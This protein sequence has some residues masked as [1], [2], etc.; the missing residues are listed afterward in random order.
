MNTSADQRS[1]KGLA[2]LVISAAQLMVI[3]DMT[4]VTVAL[5]SI[6]TGLHFSI[7][8]LVWVTTA[9]SLTFGGLL[10]F[11]GRTGDLFGRRRMFMVGIA[12]FAAASLLGGFAQ[13]PL[14][15][16]MTR[17]TQGVGAAIAS[18]T[19]LS[20]IATNFEE[21]PIRARAMG[22]YAAV[23]GSGAG[24]GLL[25]GGI[26]VNYFSWRWVLF[27]NVP[28]GLL[29]L[30]LAPRVLRE[31]SGARH[32]RLDWLG[33]ILA[34]GGVASLVYGLTNASTHSWTSTSTL[35]FLAIAVVSLAAFVIA[36]TKVSNPL[37][38]L[39][40]FRNRDRAGTYAT[41][42]L[43][44]A[45]LYAIFYFMTLLFQDVHGYSPLRTGLYFLPF[46]AMVAISAQLSSRLV[47]RL[48]PRILVPVGTL[49]MGVGILWM[50]SSTLSTSY[51]D[52]LPRFLVTGLGMGLVF[53]P[54]TLGALAGVRGS[55]SGIASALLNTG[56]QVGGAV[57]L[58][59]LSTLAVSSMKRS[60][61][62]AASATHGKITPAMQLAAQTHGYDYA[63][64]IA[65]V[66]VFA[67]MLIALFTIHVKGH[68]VQDI[69]QVS[70]PIAL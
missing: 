35:A 26:I 37:M 43:V 8:N 20:L 54:L 1:H 68:G 47:G 4:I 49:L 44:G 6:L 48:G 58:A 24:I 38:P 53:V 64:G 10:L 66:I 36:E 34:T 41:M 22:I 28:I 12:I 19:A 50:H 56:Q 52:T 27:V 18:P 51:L 57:G 15:L 55:E 32:G 33:A 70:E 7:N 69:E 62:H 59:T 11:G 25:A 31:G 67:G 39:K 16:I 30:F 40:I 23:S 9:Y 14:W 2:L 65:A 29:V 5:P 46:A 63:F 61:S 17:A 3:L 45:G 60:L 42:F 21:G 13:T